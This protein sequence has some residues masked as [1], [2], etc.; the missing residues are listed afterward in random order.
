M[1]AARPSLRDVHPVHVDGLVRV[2]RD[3]DGGYVVPREVIGQSQALLSLGINDDWSFEEGALALNPRLVVT[4]VD[5][6]TGLGRV[7]RK[8]GQKSVDMIG[9]LLSLQLSK[10]VRDVR[11]FAKPLAFHRFFSRHEL[12]PLMVTATD[13][14]GTITLPTLMAKVTAG[15]ADC[16]VLVKIDIEGAEYDVLSG[17]IDCLSQASALLVEFHRL[18]VNW[19]RFVACLSALRR[20]FHVVHVHGNNFDGCIEGTAVP[21]TLELTL[22]NRT[23]LPAAPAPATGLFPRAGLDMPNTRKR[24]DLPLQFD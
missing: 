21:Q 10:F 14:P 23:L 4:C 12:L 11:Y 9:H 16:R 6:T 5:G 8:A 3:F 19:P 20:T 2:G 13:G 22:V 24:P 18:N 1:D 17:P 15:R 7:V